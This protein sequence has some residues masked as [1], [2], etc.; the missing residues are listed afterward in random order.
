MPRLYL[1]GFELLDNFHDVLV[2]KEANNEKYEP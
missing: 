2:Q 1:S